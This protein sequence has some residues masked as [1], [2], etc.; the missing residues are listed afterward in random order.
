MNELCD[1]FALGLYLSEH[2]CMLISLPEEHISCSKKVVSQR[3]LNDVFI[4]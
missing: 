2:L 3:W 4:I 1:H